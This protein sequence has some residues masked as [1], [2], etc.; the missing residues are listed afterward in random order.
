M[1]NSLSRAVRQGTDENATRETG[2]AACNSAWMNF[3]NSARRCG[4]MRSSANP[5]T[6]RSTV[7]H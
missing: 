4:G 1:G 5:Q 2:Y 7:T 3:A 6:G